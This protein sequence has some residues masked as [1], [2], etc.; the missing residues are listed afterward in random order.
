M[1]FPAADEL[2]R[3]CTRSAVHLETRD[4]YSQADPMYV[5]WQDGF[6]YDPGDQA[7]WWRPWLSLVAEVRERG[8]SVRRARIVSEPVSDYIRFEHDIT[9]MNVSAGEEVRWLP[10]RRTSHLL[11]PGNDFWV[12]DDQ[13]VLWNHFTGDG[14]VSPDGRELDSDPE[15]VKVC[16]AAFET[17]WDH[18]VPH[19]DYRIT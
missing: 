5:S 15:S 4:G 18:A 1:T 10:R 17:V 11:L 3:P 6:R 8:V 14:E 16:S 9:F 19:Q 12:F 13:A 2:L 7:S